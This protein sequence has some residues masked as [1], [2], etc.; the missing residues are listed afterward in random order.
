MG[1]RFKVDVH[2]KNTHHPPLRKDIK[3]IINKI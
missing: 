1:G 2:K 3:N